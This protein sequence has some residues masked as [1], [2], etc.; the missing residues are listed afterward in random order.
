M[1]CYVSA[2]AGF[3]LLGGSLWTMGATI[4]ETDKLKRV[5]KPEQ[6]EVYEGIVKERRNH[7]I[8]GLVLGL[9][10]SFFLQNYLRVRS[11]FHSICLFMAVTLFVTV[12]YYM[13][14][15]KSDSMLRHL[16]TPEQTEAWLEVYK[17]MKYRYIFGFVLGALSSVAFSRVLC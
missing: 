7:Y 16:D 11:T 13:L 1:N 9:L 10:T 17:N 15:P 3:S 6:T 12:L 2:A 8:Q 4:G 5:L 14:A